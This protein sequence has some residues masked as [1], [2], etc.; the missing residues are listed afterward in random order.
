M[1][2]AKGEEV[3]ES[4]SALIEVLVITSKQALEQGNVETLEREQ[5]TAHANA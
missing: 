5:R 2:H 1:M 4:H 3:M